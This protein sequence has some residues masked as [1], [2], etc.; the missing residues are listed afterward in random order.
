MLM[1]FKRFIFNMMLAYSRSKLRRGLSIYGV[2]SD[3]QL[4][5]KVIYFLSPVANDVEIESEKIGNVPVLKFTPRNPS[6]RVILYIHGGAFVI[7]LDDLKGAYIPFLAR[8]AKESES[9]VI[10]PDYRTAPELPYPTALEDCISSYLGLIEQGVD[11]KNICLMGDS[12]GAGLALSLVLSLRDKSL[13][14]PSCIVTIS[15]WADLSLTGNSLYTRSDRDPMFSVDPIQGFANHYLQGASP[16]DPLASPFYGEFHGFPPMYMMVGGRE[17]LHDDTTRI[18]DKAR[19]AGVD[20]T[21]DDDDAM[22]HIYPIFFGVIKE[23]LAGIQRLAGFV[24]QRTGVV[25]EDSTSNR[26]AS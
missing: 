5:A 16:R 18:A 15:A 7:N 2:R 8:L 23:G 19:E 4:F 17:M 20:V 10:I 22:I 26:R 3:Y 9:T 12:C 1:A 25:A 13:P 24:K 11:P 21:L 6:S 14:L